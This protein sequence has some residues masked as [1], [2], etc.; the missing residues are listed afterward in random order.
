M[1][2]FGK[3]KMKKKIV[4]INVVCNGSTGKIVYD[5]A[6]KAESENFDTYC[7]FGRGNP[8]KDTKCIKFGNKL[9]VLLHVLLA[10]LGFNG[11]GSYFETKKMVKELRKINPDII[12]MHNI[13]GYYIN[14]KVLFKYL[15]N[16][17]K[18]K[19]IWMLHDC[20]AFTGHCS[21]YS[22]VKC[23]KWQKQC[24]HCPQLKYYPKEY[25]D[26]T[27]REF[28][29][30]KEL[31]S[32]LKNVLL[33]TPSN[34]LENQVKKSFLNQYPIK[35]IHNGIDFDIFKSTLDNDIYEKY[36][37]PRGKKILLGVANIWEGRKGF[38]IFLEMSKIIKD[39]EV[40]VL[41]GLNKKQLQNLPRNIVGIIRT[42]NQAELVKIYSIASVFVNPSTE[43]TFSLVTVEAMACGTPVVV[44]GLTAPRELVNEK[45]GLVLDKY[46]AK[47]YYK[48]YQNI[49]KKNL[50]KKD[51][52][53][54]AHNFSKEKMTQKNIEI[55]KEK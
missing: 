5:I 35:T 10:R 22:T 4:L 16:E 53:N 40:I 25:F 44:C 3:N 1:K 46:T 11:S 8:K 36:N 47:D 23:F 12:H 6:K 21:Y 18:G 13:H 37:I 49:M 41:V 51:I 39:E 24:H 33:V 34:W 45:V 17:Y 30:K 20:W 43:E 48:A 15:K 27:K 19:I 28:K 7:F 32:G 54:H 29:L 14:F 55:Y 42:D 38:N 52:I 50:N 26:T 9:S 2:E 31:F